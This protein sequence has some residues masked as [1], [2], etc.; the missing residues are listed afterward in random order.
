MLLNLCLIYTVNGQQESLTADQVLFDQAVQR[1]EGEDYAGAAQ[2]FQQFMT[3]FPQSQL[4]GRAHY[5]LALTYDRMKDFE[6]S[7]KLFLEILEQPYNERDENGLM[8][9]YTLY[10]HH[11]CRHLAAMALK[12]DDY[13]SAERYIHLFDKK[14][15]YQ[16]FCGNEWSAYDMYK[17]VMKARVY[18]GT[19]RVGKAMEELLP[20]IFADALASND[21]VLDELAGILERNYMRD[22]IQQ[23]FKRALASLEVKETKKNTSVTILLYGVT[24]DVQDFFVDPAADG[25]GK[26]HYQK[27]VE[28]NALFKKFL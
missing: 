27:I 1:F 21:D 20:Y 17:A 7:K 28:E 25:S 2:D 19:N 14:Y 24:I 5:N 16:H 10:K 9:P 11:S 13:K 23:E 18:E 15:P 26:E 22:A 12:E 8:E 4:L 3:R 6:T